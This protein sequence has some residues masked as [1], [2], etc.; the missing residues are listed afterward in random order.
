M[1]AAAAIIT[2]MH[3][4]LHTRAC[5]LTCAPLQKY[6]PRPNHHPRFWCTHPNVP[7][8]QAENKEVTKGLK[9][10]IRKKKL[11]NIDSYIPPLLEAKGQLIRVGR[12]MRECSPLP[13]LKH[14]HLCTFSPYPLV[15]DI[16]ICCHPH[17]PCAQK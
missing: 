14:S 4:G 15:S 13:P 5:A 3:T 12:V 9:R 2:T 6:P 17:L 7:S 1:Q 11:D 16:C 8:T 10:Y